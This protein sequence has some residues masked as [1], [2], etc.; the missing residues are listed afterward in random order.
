MQSSQ[1]PVTV[2]SGFL[3]AGKTTL[4]NHVLRNRDG[5]RVAVIVNDM[6]SV[7]IDAALVKGGEAALSRTEEKLVEMQNGC[8]CCTLREDLLV[9]VARLAR[10]GRFDAL[11][12]ESTGISEP[13]PVAETFTFEDENGVSLSQL[14][15][16]D[17]MVTVIDAL[18]FLNDYQQSDEL[19]ARGLEAGDEDERTITDLLVEQVEFADLLVLNK[20]DLVSPAEL[21]TLKGVL[22]KLNPGARLIES[23]YGQVAPSSVLKTGLFNFEKAS[24]SAGWLKILRG[25]EKPETEEY[26]ISSFVY[27]AQRPFHPERLFQL[28]QEGWKSVIRS[29]GFFWIATRPAEVGVWSQAG[30]VSSVESGGEWYAA[31][32]QE[33]WE[34]DPEELERIQSIWDE[35]FGDRQQ[36]LVIITL[37]GSRHHDELRSKLDACL[38]SDTE[39]ALGKEHWL[40]AS[41]PFPS[42][43]VPHG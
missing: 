9:E 27:R 25:E 30:L 18:N 10:E 16:L 28:F 21:D 38:L 14:A 17:T 29:K 19:K 39:L 36:E 26:G 24:E 6:S 22:R 35:Q 13:L 12:I 23:R 20:T 34:I 15:R 3:G 31:Q 1:L 37:E 42:W 33:D 32:P 43:Q 8:I 41:D 40:K 11:L 4:L 7:N 2:L 5:M